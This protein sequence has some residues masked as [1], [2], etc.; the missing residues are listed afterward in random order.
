[1]GLVK[2][3]RECAKIWHVGH[4]GFPCAA[5]PLLPGFCARSPRWEKPP[6]SRKAPAIPEFFMGSPEC[7]Q[8][9][10]FPGF[11]EADPGEGAA[12]AVLGFLRQPPA[13]LRCS[14]P[15]QAFLLFLLFLTARTF[16]PGLKY[17]HL[18]P[19]GS[20]RPQWKAAPSRRA[21]LIAY[22]RASGFWRRENPSPRPGRG[23]GCGWERKSLP[24]LRVCHPKTLPRSSPSFPGC[25]AVDLAPCPS[26]DQR[27]Q[28]G[29]QAGRNIWIF[30][31]P[32]FFGSQGRL[33]LLLPN[34][35]LGSR[36]N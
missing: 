10:L 27:F 1:M 29:I 3:S 24:R 23:R 17:S 7:A 16:P 36:D 20:T 26:R 19:R 15:S 12:R 22:G 14:V 21:F 4:R 8:T 2:N 18:S 5:P 32:P 34:P 33:L 6:E 31:C 9:W 25:R 13:P 30:H 28:L 35:A 11:G